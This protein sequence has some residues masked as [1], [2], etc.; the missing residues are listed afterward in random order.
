M[1]SRILRNSLKDEFR[2]AAI[3]R[4]ELGLKKA[5]WAEGKQTSSFSIYSM[6]H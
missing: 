4:G 3:K 1:C 6:S 2:A 5:K